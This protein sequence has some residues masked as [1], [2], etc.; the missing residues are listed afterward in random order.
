MS[1][2]IFIVVTIGLFVGFLVLTEQE[3][4]RGVRVFAKRRDEL[5]ARVARF[6]F[7][8]THVDFKS[9]ARE[10]AARLLHAAS[11]LAAHLSLRAVR[12]T[13]RAL[14]R[15]VRHLRTKQAAEM[16]AQ[17]TRDFV[18]QLSAFKGELKDS[19]PEIEKL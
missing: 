13:E 9:F 14:T 12:A 4:T 8:I 16:P 10:E 3:R 6:S 15:L 18:K 17:E 2:L 11:H 1:Y 19:P 7:I 5:D